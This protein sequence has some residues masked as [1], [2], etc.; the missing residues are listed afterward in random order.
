[1]CHPCL[2]RWWDQSWKYYLDDLYQDI[3]AGDLDAVVIQ[4]NFGFFRLAALARLI[5]RLTDNGTA[6]YLF[7]HSTTDV[8][9]PDV[10]I[11]LSDAGESLARARRLLVHSA[12]VLN[13]LHLT[14]A[15]ADVTL[16]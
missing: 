12:H 5:D 2:S 7:F 13:R 16:F 14:G 3:G 8:E 1:A 15:V 11:R 9:K 4:F 10:T 6:V